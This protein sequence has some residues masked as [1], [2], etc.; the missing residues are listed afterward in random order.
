MC[1]DKNAILGIEMFVGAAYGDD[2]LSQRYFEDPAIA[3]DCAMLDGKEELTLIHRMLR[4]VFMDYDPDEKYDVVCGMNEYI[5]SEGLFPK[6]LRSENKHRCV[7][8]SKYKLKDSRTRRRNWENT[9]D[10]WVHPNLKTLLL[11]GADS[12]NL[13][14]QQNLKASYCRICKNCHGKKGDKGGWC[15]ALI[16]GIVYEERNFEEMC[17]ASDEWVKLFEEFE[18]NLFQGKVHIPEGICEPRTDAEKYTFFK[19]TDAY[20]KDFKIRYPEYRAPLPHKHFDSTKIVDD[21]LHAKLHFTE[22]ACGFVTPLVQIAEDIME[23]HALVQYQAGL[24][25]NGLHILQ[26]VCLL[27]LTNFQ[28]SQKVAKSCLL[29]V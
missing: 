13:K 24:E 29:K 12:K 27:K 8:C 9:R 23:G 17:E 19:T 5:Q 20:T 18:R 2:L 26:S 3:V 22:F 7:L 15:K 10:I 21:M 14:Y 16:E 6:A 11:S 28:T 1:S 25:D 4:N